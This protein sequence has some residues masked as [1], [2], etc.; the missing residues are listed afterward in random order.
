MN[1]AGTPEKDPG[2][3]R[4]KEKKFYRGKRK[5]GKEETDD[6]NI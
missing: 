5:T 4:L 2:A 3:G 1:K 6:E